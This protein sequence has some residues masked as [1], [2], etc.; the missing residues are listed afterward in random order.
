[1]CTPCSTTYKKYIVFGGQQT[2]RP[3]IPLCCN[4]TVASQT[5]V[6]P[7]SETGA[8][9]E[10]LRMQAR[11]CSYTVRTGPSSNPCI[12]SSPGPVQTNSAAPVPVRSVP[13]SST[14]EMKRTQTIQEATDPTNP[15]TR[16][17]QFFRPKPPQ[18]PCPERLPNN[19]PI[20]PDRPCVG[21]SRF[22]SSQQTLEAQRL[23]AQ[24]LEVQPAAQLQQQVA[25]QQAA[26]PPP[27]A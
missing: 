20:P 17:E 9:P 7:Y 5:L 24:L 22:A 3:T 23:E 10:S 13:A 1:M 19:L 2:Q 6:M 21:F 18:P 4:D 16:F 8:I 26:V 27:V 14:T 25:P 11:A 15:A 12:G